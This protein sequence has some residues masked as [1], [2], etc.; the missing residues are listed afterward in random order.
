VRVLVT[1]DDGV[2]APGI[3]A[4]AVGLDAAGFDVIV[5][6]P[7]SDHSG[8]GAALGDLGRGSGLRTEPASIPGAP[9]I[10][11][12]SLAGPPALC[13]LAAALGGFGEAPDLV[14]S[15]INPG[16]NTGRAVLHSGTV[17]A[18]L[19][20]ANVGMS[21]VAVSVATEGIDLLTGE[22]ADFSA[23]AEVAA[24]A[25]EWA[26][27]APARTVLNVNLP[28]GPIEAMARARW[29]TL[30]PFGTVRATLDPGSNGA[31][32]MRV[33]ETDEAL[34]PDCDT[35]VVAAGHVAVTCLTGIRADEW[36]PVAAAIDGRLAARR[37][38]S[39]AVVGGTG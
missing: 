25:V 39:E 16:N 18:A 3:H 8:Y 35:A 20:A 10:E 12:H 31:L 1:N 11:A 9:H 7:D 38:P 27:S 17:G 6:A 34:P 36:R 14:A 29:A 23:S 28:A 15:G 4:L 30:A 5:V 37:D 24:A 33:E 26:V 19:T 21:G 13:V 22:V 32:E 2:A